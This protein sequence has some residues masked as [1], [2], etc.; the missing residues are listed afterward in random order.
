MTTHEQLDYSNKILSAQSNTDYTNTLYNLGNSY[1]QTGNFKRAITSYQDALLYNPNHQASQNNIAYAKRAL[2]A[3][4]ERQKILA[5]T[6]R[7]G[8]GPQSARAVDNIVLNEND[9]VSLDESESDNKDRKNTHTD[10]SLDIPE[11]IILKGLYF[12]ESSEKHE[13]VIANN[14]SNNNPSIS[15]AANKQ[16]KKIY[17]NQVTLWRRIFEIEEGYPAPL[18]EPNEIPGILPW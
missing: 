13:E 11:F 4:E 1:F 2:L 15:I 14:N 6:K 8:S 10:S 3:V 5:S 18:E 12:A 16:F 17:D 7:A 9:G